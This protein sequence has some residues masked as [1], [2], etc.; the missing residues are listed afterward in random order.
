M[1]FRNYLIKSSKLR[2]G[3]RISEKPADFFAQTTT[4]EERDMMSMHQREGMTTQ[5]HEETDRNL[6]LS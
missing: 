1:Y 5:E 2:S 6:S 3:P 4:P